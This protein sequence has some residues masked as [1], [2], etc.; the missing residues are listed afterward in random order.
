MKKIFWAAATI[1][2][3]FC[4][5]A[6]IAQIYNDDDIP[7]LSDEDMDAL[8][9]FDWNIIEQQ[10]VIF[11]DT[12]DIIASETSEIPR[13]NASQP[14]YYLLI[15]DRLYSPLNSDIIGTDYISILYKF[16]HGKN[17]YL[18]ALYKSVAEEQVFPQFPDKSRVLVDLM[19]VRVDSIREYIRSST[20]RKFVTNRRVISDLDAALL[21]EFTSA[22]G[23]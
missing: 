5:H 9:N 20:F 15:L 8:E 10:P 1:L 6:V 17:G 3:I 2:M 12:P 22:N 16:K 21:K 14:V 4:N 18:V 13:L 23:N 7:Y 19:S 11:N